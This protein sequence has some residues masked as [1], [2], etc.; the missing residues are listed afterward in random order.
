MDDAHGCAWGMCSGGMVYS[1]NFTPR[2]TGTFLLVVYIVIFDFE[3]VLL[4]CSILFMLS[5]P[6]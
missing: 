6:L 2:N 1:V 5:V 3:D 4:Q